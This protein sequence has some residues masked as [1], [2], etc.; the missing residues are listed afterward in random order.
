MKKIVPVV[1][2]GG[3][4][5]AT[6]DNVLELLTLGGRCLPHALMMMIPEAWED[7]RDMPEWLRE[8]YA[9]HSCLIEPWDG[10]ASVAFC[11]GRVIGATLDRN[12][13]RPGRWQLTK[14]GY[15]VLASRDRRARVPRRRGRSQGPARSRQDLLRQPRGR[16]HRRGR[17]DQARGR[18]AAAVRPLVPRATPSTSTTCPNGARA[19]ARRPAAARASCCSA[20]R[21]RTCASRSRRMGGAKAEEPLGSMGNDI[22]LAVLSDAGP[23]ALQLLQAAVRAGHQPADRP[24]PREGRDEPVDRRRRR[25]QPARR[26]AGARAPARDSRARAHQRRPREAPPGRPRRVLRRARSTRPGRSARASRAGDGDGPPLRRGRR[27]ARRRRQH[28]DPVRPRAP[29]RDRAPV[30]ALLATAGVHHHLV[31]AGTRL[32]LRPGR[33]VRRAARGAPLL[34]A[35]RLRR[36][37]GQPVPGVRVA[38]GHD[39]RAASC[40][41]STTWSAPSTT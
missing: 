35:D 25:A 16:P 36:L 2:P 27:R 37:G 17:R 28:P 38:P 41:A 20:T 21:R 19:R 15:V 34:H 22:A 10:P 31:R 23:A 18:D 13:L 4:D 1:R 33:R 7:R 9:Y 26:D 14:D 30:P 12:G 8:F 24:D 5:S 39:R 40:P 29:A 6:F 11:D 32:Q 3:S